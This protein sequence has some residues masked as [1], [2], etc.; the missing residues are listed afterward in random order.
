MEVET[1]IL[2]A[3]RILLPGHAV[4]PRGCFALER[5]AA[6]TEP[7]DGEMVEQRGDPFLLPILCGLPHAAQALGHAIPALSRG[8]ARLPGVLLGLHPSLPTLR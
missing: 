6:G 2:Q 7:I 4:Y 3:R 8:R 1:P 5:E